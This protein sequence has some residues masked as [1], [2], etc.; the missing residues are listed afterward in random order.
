MYLAQR[1]GCGWL[2]LLLR[3][4]LHIQVRDAQKL[5]AIEDVATHHI[6]QAANV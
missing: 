2:L 3:S 5:V 1:G 6:A 4:G